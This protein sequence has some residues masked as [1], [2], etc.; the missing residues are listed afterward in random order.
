M[1]EAEAE[2][3]PRGRQE[4]ILRPSMKTGVGED[5]KL[6]RGKDDKQ[7]GGGEQ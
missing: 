6:V 1:R 5:K 4:V 2:L 3:D 7:D